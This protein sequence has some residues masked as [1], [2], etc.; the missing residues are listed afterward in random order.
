MSAIK[1]TILSCIALFLLTDIASGAVLKQPDSDVFFK[2]KQV[3]IPFVEN[4]GQI[5]D[6]NLLF[7][8]NTFA[9]RVSVNKD[10]SI[11]YRLAGNKAGKEKQLCEFREALVGALKPLPSGGQPAIAKVSHFQGTDPK[12]WK[13][14][15]STYHIVDMGEIY[16]GIRLT[17][18]AQGNNV[19]KIFHVHPGT[20]AQ[21]IRLTI[22]GPKR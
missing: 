22:D 12:K 21:K 2:T 15:L 17:L 4:K 1:A 3:T 16:P 11:G 19:E 20:D 10:G 18:K 5:E 7:Y 8:S 13:R 14:N 9:C 6:P